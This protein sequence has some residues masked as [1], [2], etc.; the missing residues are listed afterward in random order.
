MYQDDELKYLEM[1]QLNPSMSFQDIM[2]VM[3]TV[4]VEESKEKAGYKRYMISFISGEL[5]YYFC[6]DNQDGQCF[7][8]YIGLAE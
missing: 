1:L 3:G 4:S 7:E 2:D 8:L 6:S 5:E